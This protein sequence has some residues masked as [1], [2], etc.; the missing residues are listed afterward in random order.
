MK[1][2][3]I[4]VAA[5][6][7]SRMGGE[8]PKQYLELMGKPLIMHTLER[9][10]RFD[11]EM[12]LVVVLAPAHKKLW[13]QMAGSYELARG[14]TLA[15]GGATRYDSVKNG[16]T[17]IDE[18]V[19]T[20]I[21]DAARPLISQDTL[22]RSYAAA[23]REGSGIPVIEMDESIRMLNQQGGSVHMDRSRLK[24]VQTPQVF[25]SDRIKQAY[26][27]A[28][29]PAFTDD[30]SVYESVYGPV[31]LVEGNRENIKIT[32]PIDMKLASLLIDSV[33]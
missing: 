2:A 12:K 26:Q 31:T 25:R 15:N 7:G 17:H 9:F 16:L 4:I 13:E 29:D 1:K 22:S 27:Q 6:S 24:R 5:G 8:L 30:A 3:V 18:G 28:Y 11:P 19:I 10:T 32:T 33:E 23:V 14:V 21:H 20:G